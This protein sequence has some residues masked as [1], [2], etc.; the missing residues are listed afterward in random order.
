MQKKNQTII[1]DSQY[2]RFR[3]HR[4]THAAGV[5][6]LSN[7]LFLLCKNVAVTAKIPRVWCYRTVIH[8]LKNQSAVWD[9]YRR[10]LFELREKFSSPAIVEVSLP[11]AHPLFTTLLPSMTLSNAGRP[12][13]FRSFLFL[14]SSSLSFLSQRS[15]VL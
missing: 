9:Y 6:D 5:H 1:I 11:A 15:T 3:V 2:H 7:F 14:L 4:R 10:T 13:S 12:F 8:H